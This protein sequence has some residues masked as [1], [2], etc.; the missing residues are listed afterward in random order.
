MNFNSI[1]Y[2]APEKIL[3]ITDSQKQ[4]RSVIFIPKEDDKFIPCLFKPCKS[5]KY[6]NKYLIY[7][8][9]NAEDIFDITNEL[10]TY[11]NYF[12]VNIIAVEY[13]GYSLYKEEKSSDTIEQDA[14]TVFDYLVDTVN[15]KSSDIIVVG[16]SLGSGPATHL[17]ANR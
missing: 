7:F 13:P 8:H 3:R 11:Q 6:C 16:R 4:L 12:A 5:S 15:I 1:V 2:M 17:A 9:A 14:L 10:K